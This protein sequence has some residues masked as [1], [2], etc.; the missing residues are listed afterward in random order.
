MPAEK[1]ENPEDQSIQAQILRA[2]APSCSVDDLALKLDIEVDQLHEL[3]FDLQLSGR[4]KQNFAGLWERAW[5]FCL[6]AR[7][8]VL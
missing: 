2:C 3:L 8:F 4:I 1:K 5:D 6:F 7:F